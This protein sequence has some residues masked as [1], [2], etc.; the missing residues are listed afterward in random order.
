VKK[1]VTPDDAWIVYQN[2]VYDVSSWMEH[3]GGAVIFT[4]AGDDATDIFAAMHAPGSQAQM[5]QFYIGD[6][7]PESVEHKDQKQLDFEKGYRALRAKLVMKGKRVSKIARGRLAKSMVLRG[8]FEKT[9][10]GLRAESLMRNKRGKIV[11]KRKSAANA[12]TS[13]DWIDSIISARKLLNLDGFVLINGKSPQG[14]A[15]YIKAK[16]AYNEKQR[17]KA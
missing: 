2:K 16:A 5:Q 17:G 3:P 9:T 13:K 8:K 15:L 11:S 4:H 6:L 10:G 1:H 7:I 12:R 14:K